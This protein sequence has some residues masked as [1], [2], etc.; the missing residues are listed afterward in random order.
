MYV[1]TCERLGQQPKTGRVLTIPLLS[2]SISAARLLP[3]LLRRGQ[4][5]RGILLAISRGLRDENGL[6]NLEFS[7]RHSKWLGR[8]LMRGEPQFEQLSKE[9]LDIRDRLG[10]PIL[11]ALSTRS[12]AVALPISTLAGTTA[13]GLTCDKVRHFRKLIKNGK[14]A[15]VPI[16][17]LPGQ[18]ALFFN[19]GMAIDA[20][21]A[22]NAY[23]P[24]NIG[25][26]YS[27]NAGYPPKPGKKPWGIVTDEKGNPVIQGEDNPFPGYFVSPTSLVDKTKK[28]TDPRRYVDSTKIPYVALAPAFRTHLGVQ[29]GDFAV[30]INGKNR[31]L[32]YAIFADIG[33][34]YKIGEGSIALSQT[35]GNNPFVKGKVRRGISGDVVYVIFPGSGN[36]KPRSIAEINSESTKL[37]EAW[38]GMEK[39]DACFPEY[40]L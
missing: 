25:I 3:D 31:K 19:A 4:E 18:S 27:A 10:R 15:W 5:S 6:T 17:R 16:W 36:G 40:R 24:K 14:E 21:G 7:A 28:R 26:D 39:F 1:R 32:S 9:W 13:G 30:V 20:D 12:G 8:K 38:G 23:H 34:R 11:R 37:F 29:L 2:P 33:P 22:P 35:L